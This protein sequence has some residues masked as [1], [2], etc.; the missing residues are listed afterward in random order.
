[1][2]SQ[3]NKSPEMQIFR[4]QILSVLRKIENGYDDVST[5]V[6]QDFSDAL[7]AGEEWLQIA[8]PA[9]YGGKPDEGIWIYISVK[10]SK[11]CKES[12]NYIYSK[13][14]F[15]PCANTIQ[16]FQRFYKPGEVSNI[17]DDLEQ[18]VI[19]LT[20]RQPFIIGPE[21]YTS[22]CNRNIEKAQADLKASKIK[23]F[24]LGIII[25]IIIFAL[26]MICTLVFN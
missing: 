9:F 16:A 22:I 4:G 10:S 21:E 25:F 24:W 1:M 23:G 19:S 8:G 12:Q 5:F 7:G 14:G 13:F 3:N 15:T 18:I 2:D 26:I 6:T 20:G 11:N 17:A